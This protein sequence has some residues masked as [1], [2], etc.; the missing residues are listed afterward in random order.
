MLLSKEQVPQLSKN[1][2][3]ITIVY[4]EIIPRHTIMEDIPGM[5]F[6]IRNDVK[7]VKTRIRKYNENDEKYDYLTGKNRSQNLEYF[8]YT[9]LHKY[10][11][12]MPFVD[13]LSLNG[14]EIDDDKYD[15]LAYV[16]KNYDP[17][18]DDEESGYKKIYS[19]DIE[20][21]RNHKYTVIFGGKV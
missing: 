1:E 10:L 15:F 9:E 14:D 20:F 18:N 2:Y 11:E 19:T 5:H 6:I 17:Y 21:R 8:T 7:T 4:P 16:Y 12:K 13:C 3:Y